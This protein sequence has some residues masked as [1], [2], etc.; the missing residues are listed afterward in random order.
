M[1]A[2]QNASLGQKTE[3]TGRAVFV[4]TPQTR[5]ASRQNAFRYDGSASARSLYNYFRDCYDPSTGRYCQ[6]DPIGLAGG[7]NGYLY[8][9]ANPLTYTDPLGL[10]GATMS[11]GARLG[12]AGAAAAADGPLPIGEIIGAGIIAKGI[13]DACKDDSCPPCKTVSGKI[14]PVGTVAYRP[15]DTPPPGKIEHGISGPHFNIYKANQAPKSSPQPCKCFWQ[16]IGAVPPSGLPPGA[17]PI[18]PFAN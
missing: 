4:S 17:I 3:T 14:V 15:L 1:R 10:T 8:A 11:W 16:P 7:L 2:G 6:F 13:Y 18:E 5:A 12:A 9:N